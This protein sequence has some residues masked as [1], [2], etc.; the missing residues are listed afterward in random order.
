MLEI[1][2]VLASKV[3]P[4]SRLSVGLHKIANKNDN[5]GRTKR[6]LK[7]YTCTQ[8]DITN[9]VACLVDLPMSKAKDTNGCLIVTGQGFDVGHDV[10]YNLA[11]KMEEYGYSNIITEPDRYNY[12]GKWKN[13]KY[14]LN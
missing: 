8:E 3:E 10:I 4:A 6:Y 5:L 1:A 14:I 11:R 7:F 2:K 12:L 9:L 13:G